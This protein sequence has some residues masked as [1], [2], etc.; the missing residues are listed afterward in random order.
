MDN[1]LAH[2]NGLFDRRHCFYDASALEYFD[3]SYFLRQV[4]LFIGSFLL[5][6]NFDPMYWFHLLG[7]FKKQHF[8]LNFHLLSEVCQSSH[9]RVISKG[10]KCFNV[11]ARITPNT[12]APTIFL[13]LLGFD[14]EMENFPEPM[15]LTSCYYNLMRGKT[16][17]ITVKK[18]GLKNIRKKVRIELEF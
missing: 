15:L 14:K 4:L 9:R 7:S 13:P 1:L 2:H 12:L 18:L 17:R 5:R 10:S 16:S 3:S 11:F 8:C 6:L